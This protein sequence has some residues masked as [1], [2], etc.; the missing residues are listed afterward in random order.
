MRG[1]ARSTAIFNRREKRL[2]PRRAVEL[3]AIVRERSVYRFS[4]SVTDLS[5]SGCRLE[6]PGPLPIG[7]RIFLAMPGLGGLESYIRWHY[8]DQYG[9]V[10]A[11][12][13]HP[14]VYDD[15]IRRFAC[16][17]ETDGETQ[18]G[19]LRDSLRFRV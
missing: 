18:V 10:F 14:S 6:S 4:V 16:D 13:L 9:C 7:V 15:L 19:L 1:T 17:D 3:R 11:Q 2:A 8:R 12:P 5:V